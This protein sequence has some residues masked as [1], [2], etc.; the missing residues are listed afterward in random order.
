M[1]VCRQPFAKDWGNDTQHAR[2]QDDKD[3]DEAQ[4]E[5]AA[6]GD[7]LMAVCVC[8]GGGKEWRGGGEA[9]VGGIVRGL[10]ASAWGS[11]A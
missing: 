11:V 5:C 4:V 3:G 6:G 8:V 7:G 9:E 2:H 10:K 1:W